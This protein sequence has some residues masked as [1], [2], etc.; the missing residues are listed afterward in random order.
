LERNRHFYLGAKVSN[1]LLQYIK[2]SGLLPGYPNLHLLA[3]D[4]VERIISEIENGKLK[5]I[6]EMEEFILVQGQ[7]YI[8]RIATRL[9]LKRRKL[10]EAIQLA[11]LKLIL[12]IGAGFSFEA[13]M[14]LTSHLIFIL[15][16]MSF[17]VKDYKDIKE[18]F[19]KISQ[20]ESKDKE[21]KERFISYLKEGLQSGDIKITEAHEVV[22]K[23]FRDEK[24]LEILCLNW[25]N[26]LELCYKKL[27]GKDIFKINREDIFVSENTFLHYLWKF[28]G[29][30]ED[31][32]YKWIYPGANGRVFSSFIKYLQFLIK[33]QKY[34]LCGLIVGYSEL[35]EQVHN[36]IDIIQQNFE[37]F[38]IGMDMRLFNEH[39]NYILAPARWILPQIFS[40]QL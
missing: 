30:V 17:A 8:M 14:P 27:M 19:K 24:I 26:L 12:I 37:L 29:D 15:K 36:I 2:K 18:A 21:F 28:H 1:T 5:P 20:D 11:P 7:E 6:G 22:I 34:T 10:K 3:E 9:F 32:E 38:R 39:E 4:V 40:N 25:D 31:P 16:S 13:G 23:K 35:D 33:Q